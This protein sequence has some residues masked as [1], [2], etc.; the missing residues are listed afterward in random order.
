MVCY[1]MTISV[2]LG[3]CGVLLD[4]LW[5]AIACYLVYYVLLDDYNNNYR[6]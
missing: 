1:L 6:L 4:V 3:H 5:C 2:L